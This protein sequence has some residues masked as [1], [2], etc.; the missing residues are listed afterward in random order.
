[1]GAPAATIAS[2]TALVQLPADVATHISPYVFPACLS[3]G[4]AAASG[5][6]PAPLT[7][8]IELSIAAAAPA[9]LSTHPIDAD[10]DVCFDLTRA[11]HM[12][13]PLTVPRHHTASM[14]RYTWVRDAEQSLLSPLRCM[15]DPSLRPL[16][17]LPSPRCSWS[18]AHRRAI[19]IAADA[20]LAKCA[21]TGL[22]V[23]T[24]LS[25]RAWAESLRDTAYDYNMSVFLVLGLRQ[26]VPIGYD[27]P[28][29]R[30]RAYGTERALSAECVGRI[31]PSMNEEVALGRRIGPYKRDHIPFPYF[32]V[33]PI[34]DVPKKADAQGVIKYRTVH[35]LSSPRGHSVNDGIS[36]TSV[37]MSS[38]DHICDM[39]RTAGAG[40]F[41]WKMDVK[42]AFK[43]IGVRPVDWPYL[44]LSFEGRWLWEIVLPFGLGS[45]CLIFEAYASA[46]NHIVRASLPAGAYVEHYIDDFIGVALSHDVAH[47]SRVITHDIVNHKLGLPLDPDKTKIE[48]QEQE[49][50]GYKLNTVTMTASCT[51]DRL[52][53][54][55]A[56]TDKWLHLT[57]VKLRELESLI[58]ILEFVTRVV[59]PGR[60]M[61]S[62]L[63]AFKR[64]FGG[65]AH[66]PHVV[67]DDVKA[68]VRWWHTLLQAWNGVSLMYELEWQTASSLGIHIALTSDACLTGYG[69][70]WDGECIAGKWTAADLHEAM[71]TDR[72]SMPYLELKALVIAAA[73]WGHRWKGKRVHFECD[74]QPVVQAICNGWSAATPTARLLR[75]LVYVSCMH[76][77]EFRCTHI[78]GVN[79]VL[80]DAL[81]R[82]GGVD[83]Y[84]ASHP[85]EQWVMIPACALPHTGW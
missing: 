78:A 3:H 72:E 79:N 52:I 84:K 43:Q 77:F 73:T 14:E 53:Q 76:G 6:D 12:V 82:D 51:P 27:G 42:S 57:T 67:S 59:R 69:A 60:V 34:S 35:D 39:V 49:V 17:I 11:R 48:A 31:T 85:D 24:P 30:Q 38:L 81:S 33:S 75:T 46:A 32:M 56:L 15:A 26:G 36:I 2:S 22:S 40:C 44:G 68:D 29:L 50:L 62:R 55:R 13:A 61:L 83:R 28:P 70:A 16:P 20:P 10:R 18:G 41:I 54:I 21:Y 65:Q 66:I 74:C 7:R 5:C 63:R 64:T 37:Q 47:Q 58:G 4:A 9:V 8:V 25:A 45:S 80:A 1:M 71:R 19:L 23:R